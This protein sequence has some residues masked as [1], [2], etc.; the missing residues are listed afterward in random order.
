LLGDNHGCK[1]HFQKIRGSDGP[2]YGE[3]HGDPCLGDGLADG[4]TGAGAV[5][6]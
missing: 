3:E 1:E 4:H 6:Q 5:S 2:Q